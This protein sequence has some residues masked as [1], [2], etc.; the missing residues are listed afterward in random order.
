VLGVV[1]PFLALQ[2]LVENAVRHG[3][4]GRRGGSIT[5]IARD[6]GADCVISVEDDGVGMD[7]EV[8]RSAHAPWTPTA[9][10]TGRMSG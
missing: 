9:P 4:A 1:V 8:L 3:L 5:L 10:T 6:E 7:P 2:P